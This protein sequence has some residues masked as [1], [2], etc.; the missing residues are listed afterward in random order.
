M[1]HSVL[2]VAGRGAVRDV[3]RAILGGTSELI[4][5]GEV[6]NDLDAVRAVSKV[7]PDLVLIDELLPGIDGIESTAAILQRSPSARVI[8]LSMREDE[9]TVLAAFRAGVCAYVSKRSSPVEL[10][11][12]LSAVLRG[13]L[14]LSSPI[15]DHLLNRIQR[16]D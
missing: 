11:A 13:G 4:I 14:Y 15:S 1:P 12:A 10:L 6:D 5:T 16:G 3:V 9:N 2:L 7:H 8:I